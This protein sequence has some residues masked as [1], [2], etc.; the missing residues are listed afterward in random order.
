MRVSYGLRKPRSGSG[1][2]RALILAGMSGVQRLG[3]IIGI[4]P[5]TVRQFVAIFEPSS[6]VLAA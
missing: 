6:A 5:A 3:A 1:V 4:I 2:A